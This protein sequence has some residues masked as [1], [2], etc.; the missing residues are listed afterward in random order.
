M[1][2]NARRF[3]LDV[4]KIGKDLPRESI[5]LFHRK[6][7][8]EAA[9]GVIFTTAVDTGLTRGNWQFR[10]SARGNP[11]RARPIKRID[12]SGQATLGAGI[13][14][15]SNIRPFGAWSAQLPVAWAGLLEEGSSKRAPNG[16]VG[17]T[18][19]RL[20]RIRV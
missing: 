13:R 5:L 18:L 19:A 17:V 20:E 2:S 16:M 3:S 15:L 6:L 8:L 9:K 4:E 11:A 7:A 12:K 14:S 10:T 1:P